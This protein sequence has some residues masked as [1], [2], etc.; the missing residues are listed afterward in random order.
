MKTELITL[1]IA[2]LLS[3]C[4]GTPR[5][6]TLETYQE[7]LVISDRLSNKKV[8]SFAEDKDG[9]IWMA[10]ARGLNKYTS[11]EF[12]QYFCTD[13][14][15]G[16][17]DN[18]INVVHS[19]QDGRLWV[20][21]VNGVAV[22][23]REDQ[24]QRIP[25]PG[26][27]R[28]ISQI[29]ETRD[30]SLLFSSGSTLYKWDEAS[31][32]LRPVVRDFNS[33]G[34]PAALI[35]EDGNLWML[36]GNGFLLNCYSTKDFTL[37]KSIPLPRQ[38]Y[39]ICNA[40]SGELWL[41][42]MGRLSI[43][44]IRSAQ[45]KELPAPIRSC[46]TLMQKDIDILFHLEGQGILMN[47][48]GQGFFFYNRVRETVL[49]QQDAD[50]PLSVP[51]AEVRSLFQD[52]RGNLWFGTIDRGYHVSYHEKG[53]FSSNKYLTD[54]FKD[55]DVTSLCPDKNGGLWITTLNDGL[56][57]YDLQTREIRS[58]D[59]SHLIPDKEVGYIRASKVYCEPDGDLWFVFTDKIRVI[60][61]QWDG[62][63]L[64]P[65]DRVYAPSPLSL[66]TDDQGFL[67]IGGFS[68]ELI[69]YDKR[70]GSRQTV[71]VVK[72]GEW[73]FV[74]DL[75]LEEAGRLLVPRFGMAPAIVNTYTLEYT[76]R[77]V[78]I[79]DKKATIR[80]SVVIPNR[81]LKD[82]GG[83]IWVGTLANGLLLAE[84]GKGRLRAV[85]GLPCPDVCSIE[86]DHQGNIW[87]STMNG[88]AKYDRTVGHFV[89][90]MEADG[91]AG[92]QFND[93]ASC[94]LPDGTLLFGGTDGLTCFN[95]LDAPGKR[96]VP[97]VFES[98]SIHN[99]LVAPSK[100]GPIDQTLS[101]K[102]LITIHPEHNAFSIS[103]AALDYAQYER[104]R[105]A[106]KMEGLDKDWVKINTHHDAYF[107][108]LPA[109]NYRLR[110]RIANGS[111]TVTETEESIP[112]KVLPPWYATPW[113]IL[114]WFSLGA[115]LLGI[116]YSF[117]RHI[118]RVRKEAAR[119]IWQVRREREKAEEAEK[120]EKELNKIQQNYFANVAHEFR[121][122][123][124]MIAG[125]AQQLSTSAGIQG[126]DRQL[127]DIIRRNATWMLSLVNQLLD[128]NRIGNSK[129]QLKVAKMD[130]AEPLRDTAS[131]F[132]FNATSKGI[133]LNTVG[134]EEP[135]TMW[136]DADKVQKV[137]MNLL[138]NALKFTPPGG[139]V[140]LSFDVISRNEAA[141]RFPL[142][143][144]DKDGQYACISV[145]D[146]GAGIAEDQLEK[147]FERFYQSEPGKKVT[148]S[149][150]GLYYARALC[151]LHHGY[152]KAFN[153]EEGG[154]LMSLILP[155]SAS[156]YTE[157]ERTD[158][159]PQLPSHA[160][161]ESIT[162]DQ[163]EQES[164]K[165]HIAIIDDDIDIANY[166]KV[167]LKPQY[168]ISLYFDGASALKGMT[169]EAPD[170]II[171]DVVMPG[172][173]G[174]ELCSHIKADL[175]LS[176]IPVVLVTA[177]VAVENQVEGLDKGADAYVTKP[178]QPAYLLALVKSL[179]ENREKLRR[180]LGSV[181]TTEEIAPEA[182][183]PR[184]A[185]FMKELYELMEKELANADL[186]IVRMTEMMKISRTKFYYKVKGLTGDN[187][188]VFF[189]RY[190]LNRAADL[191]KE[192]KYNMSEIAWMTGFNTLS[193]FST[194]FKKQFGVPPSEYVG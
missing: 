26:E 44:D 24:F 145:A 118:R 86:E 97:L 15:L 71:S 101:K 174:Y 108:H 168:R 90:Y 13:D 76:N 192:G 139:K 21:T 54:S 178:F 158:L 19:A 78:S 179:L 9:H 36:S 180:Q 55:K 142:T 11:L 107:A 105:Y 161:A 106:Y 32:S 33:F 68:G 121:T 27:S 49:S 148:G 144:A 34:A 3:S 152:I 185:A 122:P 157:E 138:S 119:R 84:K 193:H 10:T 136:V 186:D 50:F 173:D 147:I 30:G 57:R 93:R 177:K 67:W 89:S 59:I 143:E 37:L 182:L 23:T 61:C 166:L 4:T 41:S 42:G 146:N 92:D 88:L 56:F 151:T 51:T 124:T 69:R 1:G 96:T 6:N 52:S 127:V 111:H 82:S 155:V 39:H 131:L 184:D 58:I 60:R 20:G 163:P 153:R 45:W 164:S 129:L 8:N 170:L 2:V 123:L 47:V 87:V 91:I 125:P 160:L 25:F 133:E 12:Y 109:G 169:E 120:A 46:N 149:G 79:F 98:L 172:M 110:V 102:P 132:R 134:L 100:N 181:T 117:Y 70:D 176:H 16:L 113:A 187:P 43:L 135:F 116:A 194:S 7:N 40:G 66:T 62:K 14:T 159:T 28:N 150:I 137:V 126:P 73:T 94:V 80:R 63:Q 191:L 77:D 128:F 5:H 167:M 141:G 83:N 171:S 65:Q 85:E 112:I 74:T 162:E 183:S 81:I 22:R 17:P 154:A 140:T 18:Q 189:K 175:Q 48:I 64:I 38:T 29:L 130:L 114:L 156:S 35:M 31:E 99:N 75:L 53:L 190:K 188:S 103:F 104:I 165:R 95:P 72:P 115:L